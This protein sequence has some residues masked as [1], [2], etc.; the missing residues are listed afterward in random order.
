MESTIYKPEETLCHHRGRLPHGRRSLGTL[1]LQAGPPAAIWRGGDVVG[2]AALRHPSRTTDP[3][4]DSR[5]PAAPGARLGALTSKAGMSFRFTGMMLATLGS[6]KDSD[7]RLAVARGG[8]PYR[9]DAP[10]GVE[11]GPGKLRVS[12]G[13]CLERDWVRLRAKPECPLDSGV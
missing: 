1:E 9:S 13:V 10:I 3:R 7:R 5:Y 11:R 4:A 8:G 6:I 12:G 2:P